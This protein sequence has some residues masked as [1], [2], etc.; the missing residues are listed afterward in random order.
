MNKLLKVLCLFLFVFCAVFSS[1]A[2]KKCFYESVNNDPL[3]AR[4]YTLDNGLKVYL[5]INKATPRIKALIAVKAGGKNDPSETTGLAHYFEHLMF[6]GTQQYGTINYEFEK[7]ILDKIEE[8][9]ELYR[10]TKN[11]IKRKNI[12]RVIDSLSYV[13]SK[14]AIPNEYDKLMTFIGSDGSNA[15]TSYDETV[16]LEDIPSNQ[17]ENW[18]KIQADRFQNIVIRGFHTELEAVYEEK[19]MSLTDDNNKVLDTVLSSLFPH[20]PYGTQ[21]ILGTHEELKNPSIT[22]IKNFFKTWYVPN[23]MAICLSGDINPDEAIAIIDKYF[24]SLSPQNSLPTLNHVD[25]TPIISPIEKEVVGVDAE[26]LILAWRFP[27]AGSEEFQTLQVV[28][29]ILFNDKAGLIDINLNQ[30]Q[31]VLSAYCYPLGFADYSA[32]IIEATPKEGQTLDDLKQLLLNEIMAL[33]GGGFDESILKAS[34]NN[35]KLAEIQQLETNE[36]RANKMA[37]SFVNNTKWAD[38]INS[39]ARMSKLDKSDIVRFAELWLKDDNY[40]VLY[41]RQ[42]KDPNEISIAKPEITPIIANRDTVSLFFK[43][44]MKSP[45]D[46]IEPVFLDF[47]KDLKKMSAK[48]DIPFIYKQN[49]DNELFQLIYVFE[50]GSCHDKALG[51]AFKYLEYLGTSEKSQTALKSEFYRM[52]CDFFI[53]PGMERTYVIL[54]GL[55]E[56]MVES[57]RYL[58]DLLSDAIVNKEAYNN[59]VNDI[60]K[61][62]KDDKLN[63][64]KNFS[65]LINYA[66]YGQHSPSMNMLSKEELINLNPEELID[67]INH[68]SKYK[69]RILYYGP[70]SEV[71]ILSL[72]NK[73]HVV[74]STLEDTPK[75][76]SYSRLETPSSKI[77]IAP[78]DANQIYIAQYSNRSDQFNPS[79]EPLREMYNEYFGN[80]MSSIVFQELRERRGLAYS[81]SAVFLQPTFLKYPYTMRTQ[82]VTQ[83][84]KMIDAISS[85]NLIINNMPESENAFILAKAGLINRLRTERIIKSDVLWA[86]VNSDDL[87]LAVDPRIQ[88]YQEVQSMDLSDIVDFQNKWIKGRT[89]VYCILGNKNDLNLEALKKIAP[90]EELTQKQIFGY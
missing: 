18:A 35:L 54:S 53:Y 27:G 77:Y 80:N 79:V 76:Y 31:K 89:Y 52:A 32:F 13:A 65:N 55:N 84:D 3:K 36:G 73:Y 72:I 38:E 34:V 69:H 57:M 56:N 12:Y 25:E 17:I 4:I 28:S 82:I 90:I 6:K 46:S 15:Y 16:Y 23:N 44:I 9:Y 64:M 62:R 63:Q 61:T 47:D 7:P 68:Q 8:L 50:M 2:Q 14:Y 45:I 88:T 58:E 22:N 40:V 33:R 43:D 39:I 70:S 42:G 85:F 10:N 78:Y 48:N 21:T 11:N 19:N 83:N 26:S 67:R 60:L 87:G 1:N 29:Q 59:M 66:I 41:K 30:K 20:H 75:G 71:E 37:H 49:E 81:V 74:P 51:L 5:T 86:Y 24:G